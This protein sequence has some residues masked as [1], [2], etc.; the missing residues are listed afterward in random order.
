MNKLQTSPGKRLA[1]VSTAC[2]FVCG[3]VVLLKAEGT[4]GWC[5][6]EFSW[7]EQS[8]SSA[9]N[10]LQPFNETMVL[11]LD[12]A[13]EQSKGVYRVPLQKDVQP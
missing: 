8:V 2:A 5:H 7:F 11:F 6:V 1:N 9:S 10:S 13:D 12:L 4:D 3:P